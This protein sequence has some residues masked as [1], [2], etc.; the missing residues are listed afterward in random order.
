MTE[1]FIPKTQT[2]SS[3]GTS[4]MQNLPRTPEILPPSI[5]G[6]QVTK[7]KNEDPKFRATM[8]LA[9]VTAD[10]RVLTLLSAGA[11]WK[12]TIQTVKSIENEEAYTN[13]IDTFTKIK[14]AIKEATKVKGEYIDFP[15]EFVKM[16]RAMFRPL[17]NNLADAK[18]HIGGLI[19]KW[20]AK[21]REEAEKARIEAEEREKQP[22]TEIPI[23]GDDNGK[24]EPPM[25]VPT[26]VPTVQKTETGGKVQMRESLDVEVVDPM[27]LL[28]V[29]ISTAK[30]NEIYTADL[31]EVRV[32]KLK[33][34]IKANP[35]LRKIPGVKFEKKMIAV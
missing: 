27:K 4:Q 11:L 16:A 25:S 32:P 28:K 5:T 18:A 23:A 26:S 30:G 13:A 29:I 31:I 10:Q 8:K 9:E 17:E 21:K 19:S 33:E 22:E 34:L 6:N 24:I 7:M 12:Q 35:K 20:D 14:A 2:V 1:Q 3:G 15:N